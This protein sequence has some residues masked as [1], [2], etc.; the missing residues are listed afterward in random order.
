MLT[1]NILL[2]LQVADIVSVPDASLI[3]IF[4]LLVKVMKFSVLVLFLH[5]QGTQLAVLTN[6]VL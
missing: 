2:V 1:E 5:L 3:E 6:L 4:D